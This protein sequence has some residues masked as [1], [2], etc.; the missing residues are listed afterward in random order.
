MLQ[1]FWEHNEYRA[2]YCGLESAL[3]QQQIIC[4]GCHFIGSCIIGHLGDKTRRTDRSSSSGKERREG[5]TSLSLVFSTHFKDEC[6][7][8]VHCNC[9]LTKLSSHVGS[10]DTTIPASHLR[11]VWMYSQFVSLVWLGSMMWRQTI[12]VNRRKSNFNV[13][14]DGKIK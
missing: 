9:Q 12:Y 2:K 14:C 4:L 3:S 6:E 1:Y 10:T 7:S 8:E 13:G 5:S 11:L